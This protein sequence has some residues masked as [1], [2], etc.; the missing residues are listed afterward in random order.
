MN[1]LR[2]AAR[3]MFPT[4]TLLDNAFDVLSAAGLQVN[5]FAPAEDIKDDAIASAL[6]TTPFKVSFSL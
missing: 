4:E 5:V 2:R 6:R 1:A 3:A